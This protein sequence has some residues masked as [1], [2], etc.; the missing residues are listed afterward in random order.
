MPLVL[1]YLAL[2]SN[3]GNRES[4]LKAAVAG[5]SSHA[6]QPTRCASIYLTEPRDNVDQPWFLNTII[7][8][9][10]ELEPEPL[11]DACLAVENTNYRVRD[12]R[13][14]KGP[15]TIDIDIILYSNQIVQTP[16]LTIPHPRYTCRRF[17]LEPLA[18]IASGFV[19]PVQL[20]TVVELLNETQDAG[21]VRRTAPPLF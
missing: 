19:D 20:K 18:E 17:V 12:A 9:S 6:I 16:R 13:R 2:G 4:H 3:L 1:T 14:V 8:A 7:E 11:L 5:L 21:Q 15:R 10:T